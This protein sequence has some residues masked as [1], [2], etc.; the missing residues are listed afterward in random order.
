MAPLAGGQLLEKEGLRLWEEILADA[1]GL[2]Q[3]DEVQVALLQPFCSGADGWRTDSGCVK[4][5]AS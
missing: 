4:D 1:D 3:S 5:F 2:A